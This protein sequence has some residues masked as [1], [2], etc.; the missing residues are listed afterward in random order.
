MT[1]S[2]IVT[3]R[4][5]SGDNQIQ[6]SINDDTYTSVQV[7]SSLRVNQETGVIRLDNDFGFVEITNITSVRQRDGVF[8]DAE[9]HISCGDGWENNRGVVRYRLIL[10]RC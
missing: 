10:P 6:L 1:L 8:G 9:I 7:F 5:Q 4:G 2:D 3:T